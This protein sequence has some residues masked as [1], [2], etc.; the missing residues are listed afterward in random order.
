MDFALQTTG[1]YGAVL[2][3]AKWAERNGMV[4]FGLPDHYLTSLGDTAGESEAFD[5]YPHLAGLARETS[6]IAL[7]VYVSP[8]TFRHP[9]VLLKMA[10]TIDHMSGGRFSLGIGTG[11]LDREHEIFGLPY[12]ERKIR[13][14]MLEDALGYVR[15]ALTPG[16]VGHQGPFYQLEEVAVAPGPVGQLALIVGGVGNLK[17]PRLAGRFADEYNV[18]PG[19]ENDVRDRIARFRA[20]A[21]EAGRDPDAILLSSSGAVVTAPTEP[22]YRDKFNDVAADAGVEPAELEAHYAFRST[23]R[24]SHEQVAEQLAMLSGLGVERFH[25]QRGATFDHDEE[26][27]LLD[28]LRKAIG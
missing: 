10:I 3:A 17:T 1:D 27:S 8:I 22:E 15:A 18:Y 7:G 9:A 12:P 21:L 14:E 13:F 11:W 28:F 26:E 19:T 23:P 25:L 5:P 6:E 20:S 16:A 4:S 24:G 2:D